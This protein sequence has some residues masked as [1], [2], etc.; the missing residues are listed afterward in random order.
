MFNYSVYW[1]Y[2]YKNTNTDAE[3]ARLESKLDAAE[4]LKDTLN[5]EVSQARAL[6]LL[7]LL[8]LP[9]ILRLESEDFE[10]TRRI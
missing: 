4:M 5:L 10:K 9:R 2:W 1:L 8:I 7:V 3:L 6:L